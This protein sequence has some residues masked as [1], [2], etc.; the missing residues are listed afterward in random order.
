MFN[1]ALYFTTFLTDTGPSTFSYPGFAVQTV[2]VN[3]EDT[4]LC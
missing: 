2:L 3:L 1:N 4:Q